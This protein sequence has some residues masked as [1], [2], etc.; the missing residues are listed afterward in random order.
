ML[1][2]SSELNGPHFEK[3][4]S[5]RWIKGLQ[6][7]SRL[8]SGQTKSAAVFPKNDVSLYLNTTS[9]PPEQV[10]KRAGVSGFRWK[11]SFTVGLMFSENTGT[12]CFLL[13]FQSYGIFALK[14][15]VLQGFDQAAQIFPYLFVK[16]VEASEMS[17]LALV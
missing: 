8:D 6:R 1:L 9:F 3:K 14:C 4:Q 17:V 11:Q 10:Q 13:S 15:A 7:G 5:E 2:H 16:F 12:R